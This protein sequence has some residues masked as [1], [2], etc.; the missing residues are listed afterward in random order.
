MDLEVH[1]FVRLLKTSIKLS[2]LMLPETKVGQNLCMKLVW[3]P[4]HSLFLIYHVRMNL[5]TS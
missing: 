2:F 5:L 4:S 3:L 1:F